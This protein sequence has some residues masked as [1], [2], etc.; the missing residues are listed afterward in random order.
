MTTSGVQSIVWEFY[1]NVLASRLDKVHVRGKWVTFI[2]QA[3]NKVLGLPSIDP[4]EEDYCQF[5]LSEIDYEAVKNC[6]CLL[7]AQLPIGP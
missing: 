7:G 6:I 5:L 3:I 2:A 1:A 4:K